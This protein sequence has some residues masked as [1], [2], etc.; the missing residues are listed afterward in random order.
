MVCS[1]TGFNRPQYFE[2]VLRSIAIANAWINERVVFTARLDPCPKTEQMLEL[3]GTYLPQCLVVVNTE[4]LGCAANT[5]AAIQDGFVWADQVSE[6]FVLH[7]EDDLELAPDAFTLA[8]WLRDT[9]RDDP[10]IICVGIKG[11]AGVVRTEDSWLVRKAGWFGCHTWGTW[12]TE[13]VRD[14]V[15]GWENKRE[16]QAGYRGWDVTVNDRIMAGR[17]Q[18]LPLLSRSQHI[19]ERGTFARKNSY[20]GSVAPDWDRSLALEP[21][22][23]Y[24]EEQRQ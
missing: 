23:P 19:G 20:P 2:P 4:T 15:P 24:S 9:Y 6:D 7:L 18:V 16:W 12:R 11:M 22:G 5:L 21:G 13:W 14:F 8:A 10:D 17:L 1:L 3:L